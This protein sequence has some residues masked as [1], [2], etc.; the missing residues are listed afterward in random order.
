M[1]FWLIKY[2]WFEAA[3]LPKE[4]SAHLKEEKRNKIHQLTLKIVAEFEIFKL[5]ALKAL[6]IKLAVADS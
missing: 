5:M 3:D 1:C 6:I 2:C 4:V